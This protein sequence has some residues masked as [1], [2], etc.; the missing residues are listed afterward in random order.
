ML[1]GVDA[2]CI[3]T[4]TPDGVLLGGTPML[5]PNTNPEPCGD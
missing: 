3:N 2:D 1:Y 5:V 4:A